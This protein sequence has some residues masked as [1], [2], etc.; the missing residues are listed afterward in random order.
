MQSGYLCLLSDKGLI[1]DNVLKIYVATTE[2]DFLEC[3]KLARR[4]G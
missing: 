1:M 2:S 4:Y 3:D